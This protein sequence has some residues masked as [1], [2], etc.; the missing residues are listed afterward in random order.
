MLKPQFYMKFFSVIELN[1]FMQVLD[2]RIDLKMQQTPGLT[3]RKFKKEGKPSEC[4]PPADAP[5]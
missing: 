3:E 2:A 5:I 1:R 4:L